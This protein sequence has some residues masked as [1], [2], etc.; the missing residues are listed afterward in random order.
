MENN[1]YV[2]LKKHYDI[3][4]YVYQYYCTVDDIYCICIQYV[5][6]YICMY[7]WHM[8]YIVYACYVYFIFV[9]YNRLYIIY[10]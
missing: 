8:E 6:T 7:M 4:I 10:I 5:Y 1:L 3:H 2:F 9:M